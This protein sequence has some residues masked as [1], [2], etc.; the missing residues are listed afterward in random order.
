MEIAERKENG[1]VV[2]VCRGRM[3]GHGA[4]VLEQA[5]KG[6]LHDDDRSLVLDMKDVPYLSSAGIRVML[7]LQKRLRERGGKVALA[8]TG[9]F[10]KKVLE[11]AGFLSIFPDYP[12]AQEAV[13]VLGRAAERASL[14][15]DLQ[16]PSFEKNGARISIEQGSRRP[17]ALRLWGDLDAVLHSR[18]D[19]RKIAVI[20]FS[21]MEYALGLGALGKNAEEVLP[22]LG[23]MVVLHGSMVWLPTDGNDTPDFFTPVRDTG[24]VKIFSGYSLSLEGPFYEFMIFESVLREGMLIREISRMLLERAREEYRDFRGVLA[25]A[26]WAVLE[27]LQSQG[28]SRSP[29]RDHA[30]PTGVSITDPSVYDLWFEHETAP[31]YRGDTMVGFGVLVDFALADQH[32]DRATLDSF[33]GPHQTAEEGTARLFSH[34]HGVVFRN[35]AYDPAALFEGQVKKI[36]A[37]GEFVDMR[38]LLD[39]TRIRK[40]KI[41]IAPVAR[42]I[43]E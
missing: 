12:T 16:S 19:A 23:E 9:D 29:V 25:V 14:L 18:I 11:M 27:G 39:E 30:P 1:V 36:L 17:S 8:A 31:R 21:G 37:Q 34:T 5:A 24:E 6:A 26:W 22:F 33:F 28:V 20:P 2:L 32:F 15:A 43:T 4:M 10:P 42:L 3:D 41:G 40:A 7:A 13:R 38:H 35:V